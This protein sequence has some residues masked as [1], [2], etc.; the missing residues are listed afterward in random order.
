MKGIDCHL[1]GIIMREYNFA[2]SKHYFTCDT[3]WCPVDDYIIEIKKSP[4]KQCDG[5][6]LSTYESI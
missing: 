3:D 4:K 6:W 1:C 2:N 5:S